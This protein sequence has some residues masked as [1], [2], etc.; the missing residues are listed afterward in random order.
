MSRFEDFR[1]R[2]GHGMR[3]QDARA[4]DGGTPVLL[5]LQ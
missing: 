3:G 4:T 1:N 5:R 2:L